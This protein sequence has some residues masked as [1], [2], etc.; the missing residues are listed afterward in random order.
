VVVTGVGKPEGCKLIRV[1]AE[2][3]EDTVL[4]ISIHG[5]FFA[6]PEEGFGRAVKRLA[7][8]ALSHL[9]AAFSEAMATEGIE[10]FGITGE[11]LAA[12]VAKAIEDR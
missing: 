12:V 2:I 7:G 6:S 9:A 4:S 1:S 3:A 5:D 10:V 11:G 8:T